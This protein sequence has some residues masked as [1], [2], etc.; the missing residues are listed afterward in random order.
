MQLKALKNFWMPDTKR[1]VTV[2]RKVNEEFT[3]DEIEEGALIFEILL[4]ARAR[5][6]DEKFIPPTARYGCKMGFSYTPEGGFLTHCGRGKEVTLS[7][8][9][10]GPLLV[11]GHVVPVDEDSWTPKKLLGIT[12]KE[13][14]PKKMFDDLPPAPAE[15]WIRKGGH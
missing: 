15:S 6:V 1:G 11:S 14:D 12:A 8:E 5:V 10:A 13:N 4:M 9:I 2:S 3:I 7:Q